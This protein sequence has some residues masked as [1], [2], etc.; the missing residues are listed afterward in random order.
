MCYQNLDLKKSRDFFQ[1]KVREKE[2]DHQ[3]L[4]WALESMLKIWDCILGNEKVL[5]R[6]NKGSD[7]SRFSFST[8]IL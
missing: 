5:M 8:K 3:G 4:D 2:I 1:R 6:L 7:T